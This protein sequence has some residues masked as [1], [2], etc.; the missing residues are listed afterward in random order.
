LSIS[1]SFRYRTTKN[2]LTT[3][4][5]RHLRSLLRRATSVPATT[6]SALFAL[7]LRQLGDSGLGTQ[8]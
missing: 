5:L 1:A 6:D 7:R 8:G 3:N 2:K 4:G